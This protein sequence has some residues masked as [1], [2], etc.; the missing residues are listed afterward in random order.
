MSAN[1]KGMSSFWFQ[2]VRYQE[3]G[4]MSTGSLAD[5]A[6]AFADSIPAVSKA[7]SIN[8]ETIQTSPLQMQTPTALWSL[9]I[10]GP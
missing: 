2:K 5:L 10:I 8:P 4:A 1:W 6:K 9:A 3:N 7:R